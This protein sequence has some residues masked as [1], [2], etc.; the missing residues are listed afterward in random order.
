MQYNGDT[1]AWVV[2]E[3]KQC[4]VLFI[5]KTGAE[6]RVNYALRLFDHPLYVVIPMLPIHRFFMSGITRLLSFAHGHS[7]LQEC[8]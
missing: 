4:K 1:Y 5:E 3:L 6:V 8:S 2:F 7:R